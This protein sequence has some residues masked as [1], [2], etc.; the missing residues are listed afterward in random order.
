[1]TNAAATR[2]KQRTKA[3]CLICRQKRKKCDEKLPTCDRCQRSGSQCQWPSSSDLV[4]RRFASHSEFRHRKSSRSEHADSA[5]AV[6][7]P[8]F[9]LEAGAAHTLVSRDIET[10][11][12]VHFDSEF[13]MLIMPPGGHPSFFDEW[14]TEIRQ[15][16]GGFKAFHYAALAC[17]A[18]H[19]HYKSVSPQM[20]E[21]ALTYYCD[22]LRHL[23]QLLASNATGL[24]H[25][26]GIIMSIL[27]LCLHGSTGRGT[28]ADMQRHVEA[29]TKLLFLRIQA[30]PSVIGRPFDRLGVECSLHQVFL[31]SMAIWTDRAAQK[32]DLKFWT[33]TEAL[34]DQSNLYL[35]KPEG[36]RTPI[37][38]IPASLLRV[39]MVLRHQ[40]RGVDQVDQAA[41][42]D[43]RPWVAFWEKKSDQL[44]NG[45]IGAEKDMKASEK[46]RQDASHLYAVVISLV[47]SQLYHR[48]RPLAGHPEPAFGCERQ[49]KRAM[50]IVLDHREDDAWA[51]YFMC[52][53]AVYTLGLLASD[54]DDIEN[55][56]WDM[57]RRWEMSRSG[58]SMRYWNDL[59]SMWS[60]RT[61]ALAS[62]SETLVS[63][64]DQGSFSGYSGY[65]SY[66]SS[67]CGNADSPPEQSNQLVVALRNAVPRKT[68]SFE[69]PMWE[70]PPYLQSFH[71][72]PMLSV[73]G[74]GHT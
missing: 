36:F 25:Q 72:A 33:F 47:F 44:A 16:R 6:T 45:I 55:I 53:W 17:S 11:I 28:T 67:S 48:G 19:L 38:G 13:G 10:A 30:A 40:Y 18:S 41:L 21:L 7:K 4:D 37:V 65:S 50:A 34:L 74:F 8:A 24:A 20:Q 58:Q 46:I 32:L 15:I 2:P 71:P 39:S 62:P 61:S 64:D 43:I 73:N 69:K 68:E 12:N 22:A 70:H 52:D 49:L 29:V 35:N 42:D 59:E 23:G 51:R 1:M 14:P 27:T 66:S 3:G 31:V 57:Q 63:P 60:S 56:R 26:N 54:P 5:L 9:I